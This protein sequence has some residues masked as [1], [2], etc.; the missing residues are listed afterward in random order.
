MLEGELWKHYGRPI[1]CQS[2]GRVVGSQDPGAYLTGQPSYFPLI[3]VPQRVQVFV[4]ECVEDV[5]VEGL[6][7]LCDVRDLVEETSVHHYEIRPHLME[8][9]N[10]IRKIS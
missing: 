8:S 1:G 5:S 7:I 9:A 10:V 3:N 4:E 2:R 6:A